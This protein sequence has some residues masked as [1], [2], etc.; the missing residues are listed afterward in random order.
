MMSGFAKAFWVSAVA[1]AHLALGAIGPARAGEVDEALKSVRGASFEQLRAEVERRIQE[2]KFPARERGALPARGADLPVGQYSDGTILRAIRMNARAIYGPDDRTDWYAIGDE[3]VRRLAK[4]SVALFNAAS[5]ERTSDGQFKLKTR[6]L[7][8]VWG[9]CAKENFADQQ[10]GAYCSGTLVGEDAVLTAGHC[11]R[12]I[13]NASNVPYANFINFIF[14]FQIE[15]QGNTGPTTL[16]A[17]Q[18]FHGKEVIAGK[19]VG[20]LDWALVRLERSVPAS[21]AQPVMAWR[22]GPVETGQKVFVLGF[23]SG[24]PLKYAPGAQVRDI[25]RANYFVANLDTFGGNSGSGVYDQMNTKLLGILVRGETD[26][27]DD[28]ANGCKLANVCPDLGCS[29]EEVT[30]INLVPRP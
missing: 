27:V 15:R 18:V 12:E 17:S 9:L 5:T 13:S 22:V 25:S 10:S 16:P 19:M 26:Y 20:T 28:P 30:R 21:L 14:G 7:R 2:R 23:P 11:V 24:I 4:A 29:G 8:D 3:R 1:G 6:R